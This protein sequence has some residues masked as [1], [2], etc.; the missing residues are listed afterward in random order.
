MGKTT[1]TLNPLHF[2]DLEPHRFEDLVRQLV[3]DFREWVSIEA[4]GRLG[5]D[6]G[7]DVRAIEQI[8]STISDSEAVEESDD[9][10][11][12]DRT[13]FRRTWIIQCKREKRLPPKRIQ[14]TVDDNLSPLEDKPHGYILAA[15]CDFS[16]AARDAFRAAIL[17]HQIQEFFLWGKAELEDMLFLP[18]NDHLLFAYFGISL[19]VRRRSLRSAIRNTLNLKRKLIKELG[20]IIHNRCQTVLIRDPRDESYP[21]IDSQEDFLKAPRWRYYI[22]AGHQPVNNVSFVVRQYFAYANFETKEWDA[23]PDYNDVPSYPRLYGIPDEHFFGDDK[24]HRYHSYWLNKIPERNRALFKEIRI[25]PYDRILAVDEMGDFY[26]EGPH[27]LVEYRNNLDPFEPR[28]YYSVETV[29]TFSQ[30][31][32]PKKNKKISYFPKEIPKP[33]P[34]EVETDREAKKRPNNSLNKDA[35]G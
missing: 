15:A 28:T 11:T 18:K 6:E 1:R 35:Q 17:K 29:G 31:M 22:F 33:P 20:D 14:N 2:E 19:Q 8:G 16:K 26:N 21:Y 13:L 12:K 5:S 3:Y 7:M 23:L 4:I 24:R 27:L 25:I 30:G 32:V 10:S 9:Q 34:S